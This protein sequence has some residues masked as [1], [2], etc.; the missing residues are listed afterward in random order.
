MKPGKRKTHAAMTVSM[1]DA[2]GKVLA[3]LQ[4]HDLEKNTLIIFIS[5][6]G[7]FR[8]IASRNTPLRGAKWNLFE[9]GNRVPFAMQWTGRIPAGKLIREVGQLLGYPAHLRRGRKYHDPAWQLDGVFL[10]LFLNGTDK[11]HPHETLY[12]SIGS[13]RLSPR[14]LERFST[15]LKR[16]ALFDLSQDIGESTD[17]A[18]KN[19]KKLAELKTLY[20]RWAM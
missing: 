9:G 19:P 12:W 4:A 6:N 7:G 15:G 5:D 18:G 17:L 8:A 14:Q 10:M 2:V 11:G 16:P 3:S 1:D 13:A 20:E